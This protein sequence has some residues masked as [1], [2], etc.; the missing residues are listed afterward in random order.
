MNLLIITSYYLLILISIT[1]YGLIFN[2]LFNLN[3]SFKEFPLI[4]I[5]GL[6]F[7]TFISFATNII[8]AHNFEHNITI[9]FVGIIYFLLFENYFFLKKIYKNKKIFFQ[10]FSIIIFFSII[11][12]MGKTHDDFGWYHLPYTLNLSQNKLQ[13]GLG[14]FNHG[15]RTHSSLFYTNSIFYLPLIKNYSFNFAQ[16]YLFF[17]T[18][19]Y[20]YQKS[21]E[22]RLNKLLNIYSILS[23]GF[24]LIFFYRL[25]EHGTDRSGQILV[26]LLTFIVL[27]F[28]LNSK[29]KS[30]SEYQIFLII[31]TYVISLKSYF[32]I[33][34]ILL[35]PL[36]FLNIK[37]I[38]FL[39]K[40]L[41]VR[42]LLFLSL[43]I[44]FNY[45]TQFLNS[46]CILYPISFTCYDKFIWSFKIQHVK[47]MN[48]WYEL[49]SKAGANPN[50]RTEDFQLYVSNFNWILNWIENYFF[51]KFSDFL[52][53]LFILVLIVFLFIK[54]KISHF[55]P[56]RK[57][58]LTYLLFLFIILL[59][60][61]FIKFPQLRY[62]GFIIVANII[63]LSFCF[64]VSNKSFS[65]KI[66]KSLK[67]LS[68]I[69]ILIFSGRNIDRLIKENKLYGYDIISNAFYNVENNK[70]NTKTLNDDIQI[71]I[72]E[73]S[74][75]VIPQ[76]CTHRSFKAKKI[77]N[78]IFYY[79]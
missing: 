11:N 13:I 67:I 6:I 52:L 45:G 1:G 46:G 73:G 15:F 61:W 39:K 36:I 42:L 66:Y 16:S 20:F 60:V 74:C 12:S 70:F 34:G 23:L 37:D 21:M 22:I 38:I 62:G 18:A 64:Y 31:L 4:G 19:F 54:K 48:L 9:L 72:S 65:S 78:Y 41:N 5:I 44:I 8:V 69:I 29:E 17:F 3:L 40:I 14:H 56:K 25:A 76:P 58:N 10:L 53:G 7:L 49:W 75:W 2:R 71:N 77:N 47:D 28:L 51:N 79:E 35:I 59:V 33:F 57:M 26:L 55:V 50:W 24:I 63:F 30:Y 43:F 32:V 27:K 68:L